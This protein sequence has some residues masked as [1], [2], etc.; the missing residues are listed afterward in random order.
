MVVLKRRRGVGIGGR[1]GKLTIFCIE[2]N[3][4]AAT[5]NSEMGGILKW[6][7]E[8]CKKWKEEGL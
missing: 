6:A 5:F 4:R 8:G 1:L 2:V 3:L 7:V